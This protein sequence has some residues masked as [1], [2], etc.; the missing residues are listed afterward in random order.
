MRKAVEAAATVP[1]IR[2]SDSNLELDVYHA[3]GYPHRIYANVM[4]G[5]IRTADKQAQGGTK[6]E[7]NC[8]DA[9]A[10]A[11]PRLLT[12][13]KP[14]AAGEPVRKSLVGTIKRNGGSTQVTYN[15]WPLYH[16]VKDK[17]K[18]KATGQDVHGFWRRMVSGATAGNP[19]IG[20]ISTGVDAP[21]QRCRSSARRGPHRHH[22]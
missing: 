12:E 3:Y 14:S 2:G 4:I 8:F 20:K 6:A 1:G 9:C 13:E 5:V 10:K 18:H 19:G 16:F 15:G 11:W 22:R 21:R 7:S 17:G